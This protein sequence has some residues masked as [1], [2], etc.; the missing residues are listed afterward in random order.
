MVTTEGIEELEIETAYSQDCCNMLG[1]CKIFHFSSRP[2]A[3][4]ISLYVWK[5]KFT[6]LNQNKNNFKN[7]IKIIDYNN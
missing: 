2:Q 1:M 6:Q 3:T 4:S 7:E 5:T